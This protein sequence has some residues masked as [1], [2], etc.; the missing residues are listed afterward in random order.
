MAGGPIPKRTATI[1]RYKNYLAT[2]SERAFYG[3]GEN[4]LG[5]CRSSKIDDNAFSPEMISILFVP[6]SVFTLEGKLYYSS[7][8]FLGQEYIHNIMCVGG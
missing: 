3:D 6:F 1:G 4:F 8:L 2:S 5:Q 7:V